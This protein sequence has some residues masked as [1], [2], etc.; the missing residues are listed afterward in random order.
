MKN[1]NKIL[2]E[3]N[4]ETIMTFSDDTMT[5]YNC[6]I[7]SKTIAYYIEYSTNPITNESLTDNV[8]EVYYDID[9]DNDASSS[10][11]SDDKDDFINFMLSSI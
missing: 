6:I 8:Y 4:I 11:L 3:N 1:I 7:D 10:Y 5:E 9:D 2:N